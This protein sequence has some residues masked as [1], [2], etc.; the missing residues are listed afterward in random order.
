M[1]SCQSTVHARLEDTLQRHLSTPWRQ[2]LHAPTVAAFERLQKMN[3]R[4][5]ARLVLDSG[6]GTGESTRLIARAHPDCLVIGVDKSLA[7]LARLGA[8]SFPHCERNAV[9]LRAELATFWR[10]A[11]RAG[12]RL[13]RH[14]L[15][16]PN[17]WPKPGQLQRR[18]HAHPVFPDLLGLGG[19]LELRTN[20]S[21]YAD[22]FAVAAGLALKV[23]VRS[24][25]MEENAIT[26]PFERKYRAS[27][28]PLYSVVFSCEAGDV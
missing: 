21:V 22:E 27:G 2:P 19:R 25:S 28:H 7:R 26:T 8:A 16:Y 17:P 11:A 23:P 3:P 14:Y 6:C 9:W 15:L 10:L 20:W 12:W 4:P 1:R 24:V 13:Q 18:W 5:G